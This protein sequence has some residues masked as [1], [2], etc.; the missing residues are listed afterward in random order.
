MVR[1]KDLRRCVVLQF[2]GVLKKRVKEHP[3][4]Y[5][6]VASIDLL[7]E[8]SDFQS[9]GNHC[10]I[11]YVGKEEEEDEEEEEQDEDLAGAISDNFSE[12]VVQHYNMAYR[13]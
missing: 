5:E 1:F 11:S 9:E 10:Y 8:P 7:Y 2:N 4:Q 13:E 3:F 6:E 12:H